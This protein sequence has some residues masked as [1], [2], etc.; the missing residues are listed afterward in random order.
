VSEVKPL[1]RLAAD[2]AADADR[3]VIISM[4]PKSFASRGAQAGRVG[5]SSISNGELCSGP[6]GT[7]V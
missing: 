3:N 4:Q 2:R 7:D 6:D 1:Q 5:R